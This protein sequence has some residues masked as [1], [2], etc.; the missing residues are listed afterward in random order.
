MEPAA[1]VDR[2]IEKFEV[3]HSENLAKTAGCQWTSKRCYARL[4]HAHG[5]EAERTV[6]DPVCLQHEGRKYMSL[7]FPYFSML[8]WCFLHCAGV[9]VR[10]LAESYF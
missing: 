6:H 8:L 2:F 4:G 5:K 1:K 10:T 9:G 7:L 3:R